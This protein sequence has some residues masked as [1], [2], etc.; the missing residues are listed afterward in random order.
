MIEKWVLL[1]CSPEAAFKLFTDRVSDWWPPSHRLTKDA[2]SQL[3]LG[4]DGRFWERAGDGREMELGRVL[5][6]EP[7]F[8]LTLDFYLGSSVAR[9]TFVE[10]TF[11][12]EGDG[13]RVTVHH[14]ANPQSEELWALRAPVFEKSW[15]A[16][17]AALVIR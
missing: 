11:T 5:R 2:E 4:P 9:P 8:R 15:D 7:P 10:V 17:L 14:R 3:F 16:V 13:T 12:A 6:W 1:R